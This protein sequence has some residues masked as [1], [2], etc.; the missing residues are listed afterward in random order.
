MS[1]ASNEGMVGMHGGF[2]R[3]PCMHRLS[4]YVRGILPRQKAVFGGAS[5]T[6]NHLQKLSGVSAAAIM[7]LLGSARS[8]GAEVD[9]EYHCV[10]V[11]SPTTTNQA[12]TLPNSIAQVGVGNSFYVEFWATDSG[13][14]NTGLVS[15][16]AD[17][18]YPE[19]LISCGATTA[20][21]LFSLFTD[22]ICEGAMIDELG[23]S[24]LAGGVGVEPEWARVAYVEFTAIYGG[25]AE[26]AFKP[27]QSESSAYNRGLIA[28][29]DIEYGS[30]AILI[31]WPVPAT[32]EWGMLVMAV[33]LL[34]AGTLVFMRRQAALA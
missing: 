9:F 15:A 17:L 7:L 31:D 4:G 20:T 19:N 33:L 12:S 5:M 30:C 29:E 14:T 13:T 26:F 3:L 34:I 27:A 25:P 18:D 2:S 21:T 1:Q 16:Y 24:Q 22:G 11:E 23:G 6:R 10:I 8:S 32:S 28:P